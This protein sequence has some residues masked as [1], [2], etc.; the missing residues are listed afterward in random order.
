MKR[1]IL[2]AD[3]EASVRKLVARVLESADYG[4][5]TAAN[6]QEA[7]AKY[8]ARRPCLVVLDLKMPDQDGWQTFE[9]MRR[10]DPQ[11]PVVVITAW[12]NQAEQAARRGMD[13]LLEKP[14]DMQLLLETIRELF[15][16][17]PQSRHQRLARHNLFSAA[18]QRLMNPEPGL[19]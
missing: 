16:E 4:V 18:L 15:E 9:E 2:L 6:G 7:L 3:D 8:R 1:N 10:V 12:P 19:A 17:P 13:A 11:V 14:L 5:V